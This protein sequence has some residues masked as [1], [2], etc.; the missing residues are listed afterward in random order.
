[1]DAL[2]GIFL[3]DHGDDFGRGPICVGDVAD[4]PGDALGVRPGQPRDL[5]DELV[6]ELVPAAD[7][8][9]RTLPLG[10]RG[11]LRGG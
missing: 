6:G 9:Q 8:V 3:A 1:V 5:G 10:G 2:C 11:L 4:D 7:G